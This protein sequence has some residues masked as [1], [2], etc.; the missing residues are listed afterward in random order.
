MAEARTG[1]RSSRAAR[2]GAL[3]RGAV[4]AP[5]RAHP[6]RH[7]PLRRGGRPLRGQRRLPPLPG[8]VRRH[9]RTV[10]PG[11]RRPGRGVPRRRGQL[12]PARPRHGAAPS[13]APPSPRP[14][15]RSTSR[16]AAQPHMANVESYWSLDSH[17]G[18]AHRRPD[19][20]AR[21]GPDRR[22]PGP[23]HP[24]RAGHRRRRGARRRA[25]S[26]SRWEGSAPPSTKSNS[27]VEHDLLRAEAVAV[28]LTL[29]LLL[30]VFGSLVAAAMPLTIGGVAVVG[31]LLVAARPRRHH[32]GL[33]LRREPDHRPR[34]RARH[35]LQPLHRQPLPRGA[36]RRARRAPTPWRRRWPTPGGPS[37]GSALTVAAAVERAARC[38]R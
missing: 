36:G 29:L 18:A 35:R 27:V 11:G 17:P 25:R 20:R 16:L 31:T 1:A 28:P 22:R 21:R 30:F 10:G 5:Q 34:A 2:C 8:R 33:H 26:R 38:S 19:Q 37:P 9:L 7:R 12:H 24:A 32:A 23:D 4:A 6:R 15:A 14:G 3:A 13:T